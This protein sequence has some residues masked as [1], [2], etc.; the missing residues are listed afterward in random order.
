[1]KLRVVA[2]FVSDRRPQHFP[3]RQSFGQGRQAQVRSNSVSPR[4]NQG[5]GFHCP[6]VL[7]LRSANRQARAR[8]GN[9]RRHGAPGQGLC[10]APASASQSEAY[11]CALLL[12]IRRKLA[13]CDRPALAGSH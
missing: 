4:A 2:P 3:A 9:W 5:Q 10:G 1:V 8:H 6:L 12:G 7:L 13:L 11:G